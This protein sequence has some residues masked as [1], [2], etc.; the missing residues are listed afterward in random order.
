M[1]DKFSFKK[2]IHLNFH[3]CKTYL[4]KLSSI[5][6]QLSLLQPHSRKIRCYE[7]GRLLSG[8]H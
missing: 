1:L 6:F 5:R 3:R 2:H 4:F 7:L 8:L